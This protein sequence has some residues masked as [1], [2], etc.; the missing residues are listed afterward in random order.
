VDCGSS[1]CFIES[2]F[3][4][5]YAL[6]AYPIT[7]IPL[8]LFDGSTNT[9]ITQAL[10]LRISF[11]TSEEQEVTFYMTSLDSSCSVVLG[12]NWLTCYNLSIDWV[13]GSITFKTTKPTSFPAPSATSAQSSSTSALPPTISE[14]SPPQFMAPLVSLVNAPA[15][16]QA[17]RLAGSR[18]FQ[19]DL[20]SPEVLG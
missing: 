5:K 13:L 15:F 7:P 6:S 18:V 20:A 2:K 11:L 8:K 10:D 1:D 16:M 12:H 17:A 3:V 19:L 14:P 9:T 4:Q